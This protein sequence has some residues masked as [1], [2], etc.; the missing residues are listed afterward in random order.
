[1]SQVKPVGQ[2]PSPLGQDE[3]TS[4]YKERIDI[5]AVS[6]TAS[7]IGARRLVG[8]ASRIVL[9]GE[10][11]IDGGAFH[12]GGWDASLIVDEGEFARDVDAACIGDGQEASEERDQECLVHCG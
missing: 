7:S 4:E 12:Q 8:R 1:M 9:A 2:H 10:H 6:S 3:L 11:T 5:P